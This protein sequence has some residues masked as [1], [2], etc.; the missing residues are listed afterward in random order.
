MEGS[1]VLGMEDKRFPHQGMETQQSSLRTQTIIQRMVQEHQ[2]SHSGYGQAIKILWVHLRQ[3]SWRRA[4]EILHCTICWWFA[5]YVQRRAGE[6]TRLNCEK[7]RKSQVTSKPDLHS[8]RKQPS[9]STSRYDQPY[10]SRLSNPNPNPNPNPSPLLTS[11]LWVCRISIKDFKT[12]NSV[13]VRIHALVPGVDLTGLL[14]I[15]VY[16]QQ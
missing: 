11:Q 9:D 15:I 7:P 3:E 5:A 2:S 14:D 1:K 6:P 8:A 12:G 4:K 10:A 16:N 13:R